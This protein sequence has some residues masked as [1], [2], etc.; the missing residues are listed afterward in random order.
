M[1]KKLTAKA[2][3]EDPAGCPGMGGRGGTLHDGLH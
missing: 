3:D 1:I 2:V